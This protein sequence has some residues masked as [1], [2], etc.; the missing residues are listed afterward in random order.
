MQS[1]SFWISSYAAPEQ[2][3]LLRSRFS[4]DTGFEITAVCSGL[5]NPSYVLEH[6]FLPV[7]YTVEE[8]REGAVCAWAAGDDGLRLLARIPSGGADPCHLSL[9]EDGRWLYAANYSGGS[10]ACFR[11]DGSGVPGER[12]DLRLHRGCGPR[13]DRQEAAHA[14]CVFPWKGRLLVCDLGMDRIVVYENCGGVLAERGRLAAPA[15]SG[16]RH[17]AAHPSHP[18]LLYCVTELSGEVLVWQENGPDRFELVRAVPAVPADRPGENTAAA[19]RFTEDGSRLLV[20][21]RGLDAIAVMAVGAG[22]MPGRPVLS[23]CVRCPRDFVV[24]GD[25]VLA[26]SQADG[27][28]CAYRL[29]E[30]RLE[31]TGM[32]VQAQAPVCIQPCR[33]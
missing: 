17:L 13:A 22:G 27:V 3:G 19:I 24:F 33:K 15:G 23:P 20:S 29:R 5:N 8:L 12:T 11:L 26:A 10:V 21:H 2:D 4:P 32:T 6:P 14:H 28:V 1:Q 9:S 16:P 31:D 18:G 30:G 7:L 25:T